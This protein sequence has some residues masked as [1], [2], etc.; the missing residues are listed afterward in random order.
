[1]FNPKY[2]LTN[3]IV[4]MLTAIAEARVVIERAKLLPKQELKLRRLALIRMTYNS[5]AIEGNRLNIREVEALLANKKIDA[6]ERDI[7]EVKNYLN[8][9]KYIGQVKEREEPITKQVLLKI[10]KLVTE[11]TLAKEFSGHYRQEPVYVVRR[12]FGLPD[13]IMYTGPEAKKVP[14]LCADLIK[15]IQ[16]SETKEINPVIAA[17]IAHQEIAAIHPFNDGNGRTARAM[18]TLI[19]YKRGYDFRRLFALEDYYNKERSKYYQAINIGK[20]YNERKTDMTSW[21]GY[22]TTGFKEEIDNVKN[23]VIELSVKKVDGSIK[24]QIYLNKDQLKIIDFLDNVGKIN[25]ND[26]VDILNCPKRTAQLYLQKLKKI[27]M[28]KQVGKGPA[29]AYVM[30]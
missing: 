26:V 17:G 8:A 29:S 18:A 1:M 6:P 10:H 15:W 30:K 28:I 22:F 9:L 20:N 27:G 21:L 5:T 4:K 16:Q 23:K 19:L 25:V 7:F 3:K 13:K 11:K 2:K 12:R 14:Q 24:S